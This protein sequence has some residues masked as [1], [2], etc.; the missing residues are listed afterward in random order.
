MKVFAPAKIN[1]F[2]YI[3]GKRADGFH[4]L[5]TLMCPLE[6]TDELDFEIQQHGISITVEGFDAPVNEDNLVHRAARLLLPYAKAGKGVKIHLK[7][8][9][10]AGGGLAG[11]SSDAA[12]TLKTLN[13]LWQCGLDSKSLQ[14]LG[15][16]LGSDVNF[17]LFDSPAVCKGRG[18]L[19][20]PLSSGHK[21]ELWVVLINPGFGVPTPWAYKTYAQSPQQGEVGKTISFFGKEV[22]LR[23][24]L[25][26]AVF[27][28]YLWIA[29]TKAWLQQQS[30]SL[31]SL[32]SGSGATVFAL[33]QSQE[34][35]LSLADK[36]KDYL[37]N[38]V[39]IK[40]TH[41]RA[42]TTA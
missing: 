41:V 27:S 9:I 37:G 16:Q 36:A 20:E 34:K 30:E 42:E 10:P 29:E 40:V 17:F 7:K 13:H 32:M 38:S 21:D 15:S 23:N 22:T 26:P 24:D 4:E 25:E 1:L 39:W 28:K 6:L 8:N 35:A 3:H 18:E 5:E 33:C 31:D 2:L 12:C 19:V 11:G 14:E